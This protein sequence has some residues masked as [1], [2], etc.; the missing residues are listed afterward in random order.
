MARKRS[1][2]PTE[3]ELEIL[4]VLWKR[5]RSS[6]REV[7]QELSRRRDVGSTTVLKLMQIMAEKG[8]VVRDES[9]RPQLYKAAQSESRTQRHMTKDLL[10]KLFGGSSSKL[11]LQALSSKPASRQELDEIRALLDRLE[12]E[13]E[14]RDQ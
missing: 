3:A 5:G 4:Q 9:V 1:N 2:G 10:E 13:A 6:V 11:V 14:E 8:L 7:H 12:A